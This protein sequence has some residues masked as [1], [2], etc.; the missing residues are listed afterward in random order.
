MQELP[1]GIEPSSKFRIKP[2]GSPGVGVCKNK[3]RKRIQKDTKKISKG[4]KRDGNKK[5]SKM[6]S[7]SI[8]AKKNVLNLNSNG[9]GLH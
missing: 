2:K 4:H 1:L 9:L 3:P 5:I 6:V 8:I 7:S